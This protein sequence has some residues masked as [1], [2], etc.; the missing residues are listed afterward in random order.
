[1]SMSMGKAAIELADMEVEIVGNENIAVVL[2]D[3]R[4]LRNEFVCRLGFQARRIF[5][6]GT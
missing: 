1:M 5:D 4:K 6:D 3:R 2:G